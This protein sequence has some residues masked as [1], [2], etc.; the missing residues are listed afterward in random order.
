[1][2]RTQTMA[3]RLFYKLSVGGLLILTS[4]LV[5]SCSTYKINTQANH[6]INR[7]IKGIPSSTAIYIYQLTSTYNFNHASFS[8]LVN[9][10]DNLSGSVLMR[11]QEIILPGQS[12]SIVIEAKKRAEYI[13]V[14]AGYRQINQVKW[15]QT[16]PISEHFYDGLYRKTFDINLTANGVELE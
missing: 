15:R 3:I 4:L 5:A 10:S 13:G 8:D 12:K 11:H 9:S 6:D 14:V 2:E 16:L 7:N 1:M